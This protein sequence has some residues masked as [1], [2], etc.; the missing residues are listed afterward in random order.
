MKNILGI[1][2]GT[3]SV[4][5]IYNDGDQVYKISEK[6]D[7]VSF[8]GWMS[9]IKKCA[10]KLDLSKLRAIGL[11]SQVGTYIIDGDNIISWNEPYGK[12]ELDEILSSVSRDEFIREIGMPHPQIIS[13]PLPRLLY[14]K[15][16]CKRGYCREYTDSY[17]D[18]QRK[19]I[20]F[21]RV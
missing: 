13:Y 12:D 11:S 15:K 2:L 8:D 21:K 6:Y 9:A 4:K 20:C 10:S 5:M 7:S 18:R 1:D 16:N 19:E 3:S 17:H 14:I